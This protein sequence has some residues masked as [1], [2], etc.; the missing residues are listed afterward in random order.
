MSKP[1]PLPTGIYPGFAPLAIDGMALAR[2]SIEMSMRL[3]ELEQRFVTPR[4]HPRMIFGQSRKAPR[5]PR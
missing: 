2:F 4:K 3:H 1:I 5:R